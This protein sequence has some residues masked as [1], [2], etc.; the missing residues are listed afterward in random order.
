MAGVLRIK[1]RIRCPLGAIVRRVHE[2]KQTLPVDWVWG[3]K[4]RTILSF[5]NSSGQSRA[6]EH[7]WKYGNDND[8]VPFSPRGHRMVE[9]L[10]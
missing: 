9:V 3:Y 6:Q 4:S 5:N 1:A 8:Q 2:N 10:I 7:F